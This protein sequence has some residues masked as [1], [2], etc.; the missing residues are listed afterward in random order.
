MIPYSGKRLLMYYWE[1]AIRARWLSSQFYIV[2]SF[3]CNQAFTYFPSILFPNTE[4]F[5]NTHNVYNFL[6]QSNVQLIKQVF[7]CPTTDITK[8]KYKHLMENTLKNFLISWMK[9]KLI[10]QINRSYQARN[11][12]LPYR[13]GLAWETNRTLPGKYGNPEIYETIT[14]L[15][16]TPQHSFLERSSSICNEHTCQPTVI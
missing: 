4:S 3:V 6:C 2:S 8:V 13:H 15:T 16:K 7:Y 1:I 12:T 14:T 5:M 11:I 10:A 9:E